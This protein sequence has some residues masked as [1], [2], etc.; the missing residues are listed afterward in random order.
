LPEIQD[1]LVLARMRAGIG[2]AERTARKNPQDPYAAEALVDLRRAY[3]EAKLASAI[4]TVV[5]SA[6]ALTSDQA[7]RLAALLHAGPAA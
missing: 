2:R 4:R 5:E 6:P 1:H 3:A 7:D